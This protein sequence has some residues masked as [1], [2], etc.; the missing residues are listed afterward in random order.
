M[1][2][3]L[4]APEF[5][6]GVEWLNSEP[7]SMAEQRGRVVLLAFWNASSAYA[8]NVLLDLQSLLG[9]FSDS[10]TL[11]AV[12][13][14][15]FEAEREPRIA[16]RALNSL[17]LRLP[18][19]HDPN[20]LLWQH[21]EITA[22]P[23]VVVIDT[24]QQLC[25]LL[26]GDAIKAE[27]EK[28][29]GDLLDQAGLQDRVFQPAPTG[30]KPEPRLPLLFPAGVAVNATRLFVA[31]TAHHRIVECSHDGRIMR[32]IGT[33]NPGLVDGNSAEACFNRPRGLFLSRDALY[34]A[35][36]GNHALR[37]MSL[38]S[39]DTDT[40]AGNGVRGVSA[41]LVGEDPLKTSLDSP[42]ALVGNHDKIYI[43]M[44][45]GQEIWEY[46]Q[47]V[48]RIRCVAGTGQ[49][50]LC[51]GAGERAMLAQPSALTMIQ[52]TLYVADSASSAIRGINVQGG[53]VHTLVG[54]GLFDYGDQDGP[55]Q[56][57]L[58]QCPLGLCLDSRAPQLWI[59]DTYNN[60]IRSLR[61]G[62]GELRR[63]PLSYSLCEPAAI[64][65]SEGVLWVANTNAHEVLRIEID[66]AQV[67]RLPIG[68]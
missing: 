47:G 60:Q 9:R 4:A 57:A 17:G 65:S 42:W 7:I 10:T 68:E 15:K 29:V 53:Q 62:G 64:A 45:S 26:V 59:A 35:D 41:N 66:S 38:L 50:G 32:Q 5:P 18:L 11:V 67:R 54:H 46:D 49:I 21:F 52:Q 24:T 55:R 25:R 56:H 2:P 13:T 22:W 16:Q 58:L 31:D 63:L 61:L 27:L 19:L 3:P 33:G 14:P 12:H 36:A 51:D 39:G 40:L 34:I 8:H 20:F 48:R 30:S 37:R 44:A 23:S 43:A 28:L 6:E 1:N